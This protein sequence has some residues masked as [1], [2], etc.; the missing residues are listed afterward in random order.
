MVSPG[1]IINPFPNS[2]CG[3]PVLHVVGA[4]KLHRNSCSWTLPGSSGQLLETPELRAVTI[5]MLFVPSLVQNMSLLQ[6]VLWALFLV[7]P[8]GQALLKLRLLLFGSHLGK[9]KITERR[10][11]ANT[12]LYFHPKTQIN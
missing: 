2:I 9:L 10:I 6:A 4:Q 7:S 3:A 5:A 12:D 1:K 11:T 8:L